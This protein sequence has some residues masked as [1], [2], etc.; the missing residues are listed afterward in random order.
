MRSACSGL[1]LR[2]SPSRDSG[3]RIALA[4]VPLHL[5]QRCNNRAACFFEEDYWFYLDPLGELSGKSI[6]QCMPMC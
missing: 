1:N 4:A 2:C 3:T 6:A 5:I